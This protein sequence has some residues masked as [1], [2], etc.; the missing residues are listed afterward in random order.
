L[1]SR[2]LRETGSKSFAEV[3]VWRGELAAEVL[4]LTPELE[5]YW[6]IDDWMNPADVH[7]R[8]RTRVVLRRVPYPPFG[9]AGV[10]PG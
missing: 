4:R 5:A 1:I 6:L 10:F 9:A 8:Q 7:H 2:V 3:G